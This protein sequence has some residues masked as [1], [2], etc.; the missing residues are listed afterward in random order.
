MP[1]AE[2][3]PPTVAPYPRTG[4][5]P[6]VLQYSRAQRGFFLSFRKGLITASLSA[7]NITPSLKEAFTYSVS[8]P[9]EAPFIS[10]QKSRNFLLPYSMS[11]GGGG[12]CLGSIVSIP[13]LISIF[14]TVVRSFTDLS[15]AMGKSYKHIFTCNEL[16]RF[17]RAKEKNL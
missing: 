17:T 10:F 12:R 5:W 14:Q 11:F 9:K 7:G 8:H 3:Q 4:D 6:E 13:Y 16:C 1:E 2:K 15:A